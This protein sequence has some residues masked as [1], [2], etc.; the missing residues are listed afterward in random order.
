MS[1]NYDAFE[2]GSTTIHLYSYGTFDPMEFIDKLTAEEKE[3]LFLFKHINRR[4]EFVATRVLRHQLFGFEHIHYDVNGAPYID[5][6]GFISVSHTKNTVGIA[7]NPNFK[8]GLDLELM[9]SNI[10]E[11]SHKFLSENEIA[12]FDITDAKVVTKIWS[13]KEALYKLSGR[14][15][16][17]FAKDLLLSKETEEMWIGNIRN[18]G[19]LLEVKLNIFERNDLIISINTNEI[20]QV[21]QNL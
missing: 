3:R 8:I 20:E 14:K 2:N 17:I 6:E 16:I 7:I 9:R 12:T 18:P 1:F 15:C 21:E 19:E 10:L 5:S 11:L 13:A 4:R